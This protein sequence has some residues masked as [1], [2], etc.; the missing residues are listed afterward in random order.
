MKIKYNYY[1]SYGYS[2]VIIKGIFNIILQM[3]HIL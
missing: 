2:Y 1:K 3:Y